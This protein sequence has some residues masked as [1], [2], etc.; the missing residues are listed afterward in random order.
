MKTT[1][2]SVFVFAFPLITAMCCLAP[3]GRA[4]AISGDLVGAIV[5]ASGGAIPNVTVTATNSATNVKFTG[6]TNS[7]G[8]YRIGNLAPGD[9]E[10]SAA[11]TGFAPAAMKGVAVELNRT[12]T[13]NLKLAVGAVSTTVEVSEAGVLLDTTTAQLQQTYT[14]QQ[15]EQLPMTTNGNGVLNLSLLQ[16]GVASSGGLGYGAGPSIGGQRPTNN[17]FTVDGVDNNSKST[18]GPV[19]YIPNESVAEFT[20]LSNQFRAEYGHSSGGQFNTIVK[21][22][23]NSLHFTIY[24]YFRNRDLNAVDQLFRNSPTPLPRYDQNR[25][26]ANAWRSHQEEQV[27]RLRQF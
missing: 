3:Q 10:V 26:G 15:L 27:V 17:N 4:Q 11:V 19:V 20:L 1:L 8:N 2:K 6:I 9:Y 13:A 16:A 25:L 18:T 7:V 22:G 23:T 14:S 5:D 21:S 12:T 24:E